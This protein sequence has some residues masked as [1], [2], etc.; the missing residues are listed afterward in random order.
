MKSRKSIGSVLLLWVGIVVSGCSYD[1][2][3]KNLE[4]YYVRDMQSMRASDPIGMDSF[5]G[6]TSDIPY[7]EGITKS[8]VHDYGA[9]VIRGHFDDVEKKRCRAKYFLNVDIKPEYSG[10]GWNFL[11]TFPGFLVF[12]PSWNGYRYHAILN[13][14]VRILDREGRL[15]SRIDEQPEFAF[16]HMDFDRSFWAYSGWW[17]PGYGVTSL[18]AAPFMTGYD[19]DANTPLQVRLRDVYGRYIADKVVK[20]INELERKQTGLAMH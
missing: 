10:S 20:S 5:M 7:F 6:E 8:L 2:K 9:K 19:D 16:N 17:M 1:L 12:A 15:V 13:T 3:M 11:V 14:Q 4:D 18:V